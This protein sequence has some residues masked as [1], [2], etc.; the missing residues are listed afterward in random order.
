MK[1]F[2]SEKQ[3]YIEM[4]NSNGDVIRAELGNNTWYTIFHVFYAVV[5]GEIKWVF[6]NIWYGPFLLMLGKKFNYDRYK[7]FLSQGYQ[8]IDGKQA[9]EVLRRKKHIK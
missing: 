5:A 6:K 9:E 8:P 2:E 3:E 4:R 7:K 1:L